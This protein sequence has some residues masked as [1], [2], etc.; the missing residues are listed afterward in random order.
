[1]TVADS[2][3]RGGR[4]EVRD[5]RGL[6]FHEARDVGGGHGSCEVEALAVTI[7]RANSVKTSESGSGV[8]T[9]DSKQSQRRVSVSHALIQSTPKG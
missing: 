3:C 7:V 8:K 1:M 4:R 6:E 5:V 9:L 2:A